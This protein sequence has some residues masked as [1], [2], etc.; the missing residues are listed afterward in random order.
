[1]HRAFALGMGLLCAEAILAGMSLLADVPGEILLWQRAKAVPT[2]LLPAA[3][4]IFSLAFGRYNYRSIL[5]RWKYI[6]PAVALLPLALPF[7]TRGVFIVD[8][9]VAEL[10]SG[11]AIRYGWSGKV[12]HV[13]HLIGILLILMQLEK[14]LRSLAGAK[15]WHLKFL[16]LGIG[17]LFATRI[18]IGSQVLLFSS[19]LFSFEVFNAGVLVIAE[20]LLV[21]GFARAKFLDVG[22]YVSPTFMFNSVAVIIVGLYLL[23]VGGLAELVGSLEVGYIPVGAFFV[24]ASL[25]LLV[26]FLLSDELCTRAKRLLTRH[27]KHPRHDYRKIWTTFAQETS[28]ALDERAFCGTVVKTISEV[29]KVP[30]V[31]LWLTDQTERRFSLRASTSLS[32]RAVEELDPGGSICRELLGLMR[33]CECPTILEGDRASFLNGFREEHPVFLRGA[34]ISC[35][36]SLRQEDRLLG[37]LTLGQKQGG[38]PFTI[39]DTDLVHA[40]AL[41][42]A[43]HI[44]SLRLAQALHQG[45]QMAAFQAV[46]TFFVH[47]LKNLAS[48]LS[49]LLHNLP[50][51]YENPEFRRDA[52][53]M[54]R[55]S[56]ERIG[57][58][59]ERLSSFDGGLELDRKEVDLSQLVA[60]TVRQLEGTLRG[61]VSL[62]LRPLPLLILDP[63]QIQKVLW[64]LILNAHE[65]TT[66][67]KG[68]LVETLGHDLWVMISVTDGGCGMSRE[69]IE[70]SLFQPFRTTKKRGLGIGLYQSKTIVEA[71]GG[72]I[73]VESQEGKG[74]TFKVI[75]PIGKAEG[76]SRSG[77]G[78]WSVVS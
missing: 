36:I 68:I 23:A 8:A 51:H 54:V 77:S 26:V 73:E 59:T 31:S 60:Q 29:L 24:F 10:G 53:A 35:C 78:Q 12:F 40:V 67:G 32:A 44:A 52:L 14:T 7:A 19:G 56:A 16:L 65:A 66:D 13:L 25:M 28:A 37:L 58:L 75:L 47:D 62:N 30:A 18:Y 34:E 22:V 6:L 20:L 74:S 70:T 21:I 42:A 9:I 15:R 45:K 71:H 46:S 27:F 41:Q 55:R 48:T 1:M 72:R 50:V 49:L 63:A 43:G 11:W 5:A 2:A 64:N 3:W 57:K 17:G 38:K 69:F 61:S 39:E 76:T 4:L 33:N